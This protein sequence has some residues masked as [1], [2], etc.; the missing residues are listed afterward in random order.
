MVTEEQWKLVQQ[1]GRSKV[2]LK[3]K[4]QFPFRGN[5]V[6][7]T[8]GASCYPTTGQSTKLYLY[9]VCRAGAE[10]RKKNEQYRLRMRKLIDAIKEKL[11]KDFKPTKANYE[12][13]A[14]MMRRAI[15]RSINDVRKQRS[16]LT[17][18]KEK[19]QKA[20]EDLIVGAM[21]F[22]KTVK[23]KR[24]LDATE[25]RVYERRKFELESEIEE[26][27]AVLEKLKQEWLLK[28]FSYEEFSNFLRNAH[29][30]WEDAL[31]NEKHALARFLFSNI[32]IGDGKVL[33][34]AYNPMIEDLFVLGGGS[35]GT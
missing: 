34:L 35:G 32:K 2:K 31:G 25:E 10:H 12:R 21:G 15:D 9:L 8:C 4:Q 6:H 27:D 16:A 7:C 19:A 26:C 30:Y 33:E 11:Q 22:G 28:T 14:E 1:M 5:I 3:T 13:Y 18:R 20:L 17:A 24:R 29:Q 23:G